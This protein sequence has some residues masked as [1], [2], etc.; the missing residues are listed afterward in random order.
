MCA[1][2]EGEWV[3]GAV[4]WVSGVDGCLVQAIMC[5]LSIV[6]KNPSSW[7]TSQLNSMGCGLVGWG[8]GNVDVRGEGG[9][10]R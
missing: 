7:T 4:R 5:E 6:V 9:G 10:A 1:H 3:S 8:H 2:W